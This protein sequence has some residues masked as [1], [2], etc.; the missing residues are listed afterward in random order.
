MKKNFFLVFFYGFVVQVFSQDT[1]VQKSSLPSSPRTGSVSFSLNGFGFTGTGLDS[2]GELLNDF[3]KYDPGNDAWSQA[4]SFPGAAR[5]NDVAFVTDS[6][7]YVRAGYDSTG[8]T[9][10]FYRYD[11]VNNSWSQVADLD[12]GGAVYPRR[13]AAAFAIG[14]K[15]HVVGG[16]DGTTYFSKDN[17][18]FDDLR[19]TAWQ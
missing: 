1:W 5:K 19:D 7:T 15:G 12:S 6:L 14:N 3:W 11:C 17:W 8:L 9:K 13:D 18:E 16:Y 2:S 10:D 4:A